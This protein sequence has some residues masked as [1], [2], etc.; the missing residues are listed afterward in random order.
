MNQF[1]VLEQI[2]L[3]PHHGFKGCSL[4]GRYRRIGHLAP[5][6]RGCMSS[7][8]M[9]LDHSLSSTSFFVREV[10]ATATAINWLTI[11]IFNTLDGLYTTQPTTPYPSRR[12]HLMAA[13]IWL[14]DPPEGHPIYYTHMVEAC[15]SC[16]HPEKPSFQSDGPLG[17]W[18]S[19]LA[20]RRPASSCEAG[21]GLP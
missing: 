21:A 10:V 6:L 9:W 2:Y 7:L 19:Q 15:Q 13:A 11:C 14:Q 5:P 20:L 18:H 17:R 3:I 16:G 4:Q 1:L 12:S 8:L